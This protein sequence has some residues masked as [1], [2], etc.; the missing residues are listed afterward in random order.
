MRS[1]FTALAVLAAAVTLS[2]TVPAKS[3]AG[4]REGHGPFVFRY[5][6]NVLS[7]PAYGYSKADHRRHD[8]RHGHRHRGKHE[9][10]HHGH[11]ALHAHK[12]RHH[13]GPRYYG[14]LSHP[15][16]AQKNY[17]YAAAAPCHATK[18]LVHD[19]Y[20]RPILIGGLMCYD[21]YGRPYIVDGSRF[22]IGRY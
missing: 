7:G 6:L 18:K 3:F 21:A 11:G 22:V 10:D 20:G 9:H 1:L 2:A 16:Y 19:P 17:G 15:Y 5:A 13:H 12:H 4:E 14:G 8:G